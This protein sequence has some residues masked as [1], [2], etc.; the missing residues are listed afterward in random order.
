MTAAQKGKKQKAKNEKPTKIEWSHI[1]HRH[2]A[3]TVL[4][5]A[6]VHPDVSCSNRAQSPNKSLIFFQLF[7]HSR[8]CSFKWSAI[9]VLLVLHFS[10]KAA[11]MYYFRWQFFISLKDGDCAFANLRS[12][13]YRTYLYV[14]V[15][16]Y[17]TLHKTQ[18][19]AIPPRAMIHGKNACNHELFI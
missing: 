2:G 16:S 13:V 4:I 19:V 17:S 9:I 5:C 12:P 6:Q 18:S 1:R 7:A 15:P 11:P 8:R 14:V 3:P 10:I